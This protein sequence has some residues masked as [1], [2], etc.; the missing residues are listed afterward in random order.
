MNRPCR[1]HFHEDSSSFLSR[2]PDRY[3]DNIEV[4]TEQGVS[5]GSLLSQNAFYIDFAP[6]VLRTR[7]SGSKE[8]DP[9][10]FPIDSISHIEW[11][12]GDDVP[13]PLEPWVQQPRRG[14]N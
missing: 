13:E 11:F 4:Y 7:V 14:E 10:D 6:S 3:K 2:L 1:I 5:V 8:E 12:Y 9:V